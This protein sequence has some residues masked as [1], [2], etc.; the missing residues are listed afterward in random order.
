MT[1]TAAGAQAGLASDDC[2]H[3][4]VGAERPL[5]QH[6][7]LPLPHERHHLLSGGMPVTYVMMT[8]L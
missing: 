6:L 8:S 1:E 7:G 4:L 5:H 2:R 3:Q